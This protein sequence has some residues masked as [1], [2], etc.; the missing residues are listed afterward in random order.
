M[1][2]EH[3]C[4][5]IEAFV[6]RLPL[7]TLGFGKARPKATGRPPYD[8]ADLLKPY[9]YGYLHQVRSSRR[10]EREC[11]RNVEVMWLLNRLAPDHKTIAQFRRDN[12]GALKRAGA[13]F[14]RFCQGVGLV[15]G[16]W[17]AIDGS[18]FQAVA[19]LQDEH[20]AVVAMADAME[21]QGQTHAVIAEPEAR[22][23]KGHGPGYN[24]Q[25]AVDGAH[26]LIVVHAVTS[27]ASDNRQLQPMAEAAREAL[28]AD[29]LAVL[30]DA[31]YSNGEQAAA[32]EAQGIVPHVPA[33][34][35][36]NNQGDGALF[37]R[38]V[39]A[40]DASTDTMTCPAGERLTRKQIHRKDKMVHYQATPEACGACP[41]ESQC[42]TGHRRFVTRHFHEDAFSGCRLGR[43]RRRCGGDVA[44][45]NIRL[46][47]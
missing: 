46:P 22:R 1:P 11:Q 24:V 2:V 27:D 9:L 6:G 18:K 39:F 34:R 26:A 35:S 8:P 23:M 38:S 30:A 44:R 10:L 13:Q 25:T 21:A 37:D 28:Q 20:A 19:A 3:V 15:R 47:G 17:V 42:T 36:V 45:W 41:L 16:D 12:G 33:N 14:V 32:L 40:Y 29:T 4:R 31:G 7:A 43:R 5:V